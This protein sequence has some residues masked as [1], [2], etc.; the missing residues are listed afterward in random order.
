[1]K[2][3]TFSIE[4]RKSIAIKLF[5]IL[6]L[7]A[8]GGNLVFA[9]K[10][11]PYSYGFED[12]FATEGW[13]MLGCYNSSFTPS[14]SGTGLYALSSGKYDDG[15]YV[16][17]FYP[18]PD[19][20]AQCL[21]SPELET[22]DKEVEVE[23]HYKSSSTSYD[24]TFYVGYS[25]TGNSVENFTWG[26][27]MSYK[28]TNWAEYK[29][30]FPAGTKYIAFKYTFAQSG[31]YS[32]FYLDAFSF[33]SVSP[34]RTPTGFALDSFTETSA[35]F[36]WTAG[37]S[38]TNWKFAYSTDADFTP[39]TASATSITDNPYTLSG[40][41]KGITY[42]ACICA[43]YGDGNYSE[44]TDKISFTPS[45]EKEIEINNTNTTTNG[46]VPINGNAVKSSLTRSQF[47]I[48]AAK[49]SSINGR[50]ITKLTFY[51]STAYQNWNLG[52]AEFEIYLKEVNTTTYSS[53]TMSDW[54]TIVYS[55]TLSVSDCEMTIS[56][57]TPYN[58][59]GG[60]LQV[61]IKQATKASEAKYFSWVVVTG[62]SQS[63]RYST[64]DDDATYATAN[65]KLTLVTVSVNT[66][67]VKIDGNGY[68][69]FASTYPLDLA[70]L[71]SGLKAYKAA[72]DG[73][74]VKFTEINQA[75]PANTGMLLEGTANTTYSIPVAESG[76]APDG[77]EFLVNST[78]GT[79]P[80]D[81]G[82]TYY[83]MIK[84][85]DPLTF[86]EFAPASVAIPSNKAYLKVADEGG[87]ARQLTCV[88]GDEGSGT[89][90]IR[91]VG[92]QTNRNGGQYFDL[93]GRCVANPTK[94]VY[95]VDGKKLIVR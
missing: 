76:T 43:D 74:T 86:G 26:E 61:G 90:A 25:T 80:A 81:D 95:V 89:T 59:N 20:S 92:V 54:G 73:S 38:E 14:Y 77:N 75:V 72:V 68:T 35:T 70:N 23:F 42:Y 64:D 27:Q 47:I 4:L 32:Y 11:L 34:Y 10:S 31:T 78:G 85:S 45:D 69:T 5:L 49:L 30:T 83:G 41:T 94:G 44:W 37:N 17:R 93:Q 53:K 67:P 62:S 71:P 22:S 40:L 36:S 12:N 16:I 51:S 82:Y 29:S 6:A 60:N 55:G 63:A 91:T 66:A 9:Q 18:N 84:N 57:T 87:E 39:N 48:P 21:V 58:Y 15:S 46:N 2:T 65:P 79:F 19:Y 56:L 33:S 13:T 1:M 50:Q 24:M 52:S 28:S 8:G 88:F 3:E 7:I